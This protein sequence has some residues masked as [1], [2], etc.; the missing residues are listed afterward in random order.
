MHQTIVYTQL[1]SYVAS[2]ILIAKL[3]CH[4]SQPATRPYIQLS[5]TYSYIASYVYLTVF[6]NCQVFT[7]ILHVVACPY[8]RGYRELQKITDVHNII[9]Y[10]DKAHLFDQYFFS[11]F[12]RDSSSTPTISFSA[13]HTN[14]LD[15]ISISSQEVNKALASL[16][17]N[18]AQGIDCLSPK[19]WKTCAPYLSEFLCHLY[20][21]CLQNTQL[22][23]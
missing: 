13:V 15:N 7:V 22:T 5:C 4:C 11:V 20:T 14:T 19:I 9:N 8:N 23:P 3:L 10:S 12:T 21:K 16:D 1:G 2:Y 6:I 17:P 18:K